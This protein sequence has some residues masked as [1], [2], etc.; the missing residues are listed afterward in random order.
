M[1]DTAESDAR[2]FSDVS[3]G[4]DDAGRADECPRHDDNIL[5]HA[6]LGRD[7]RARM[8]DGRRMDSRGRRHRFAN[9]LRGD[10]GER[11]RGIVDPDTGGR[12]LAGEIARHE[13][14]RGLC[15]FKVGRVTRM[16]E[17]GN[18]SRARGVEGG[19]TV[20]DGIARPGKNFAAHE[21]GEF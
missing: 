10:A 8:H 7:L 14:S 19:G 21:G 6:G 18:L 4:H 11:T 16:G 3:P 20:D 2:V 5:A 13:D 17:K 1:E 12:C 9:E 15:R